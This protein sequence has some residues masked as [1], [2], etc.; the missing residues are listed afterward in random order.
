[1]QPGLCRPDRDPEGNGRLLD[2]AAEVEAQDDDRALLDGE[3]AKAGIELLA[4]DDVRGRITDVWL[5]LEHHH[6]RSVAATPPELVRDGAHQKTAKPG[7]ELR[8][9]AQRGQ[10]APATDERFLNGVLGAIG[11]AQ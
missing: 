11:V 1:M 8:Y 3:P 9:L 6:G 2:G 7:I 4:D 10:V 5:H